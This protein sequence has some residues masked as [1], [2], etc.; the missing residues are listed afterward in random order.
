MASK[1]FGHLK[2]VNTNERRKEI[3]DRI[4]SAYQNVNHHKV[5]KVEQKNV[6]VIGRTRAGKTTIKKV[7]VDPTTVAEEMRLAAQTRAATFESFII[8]DDAMVVNI[9]DTPG[10]FEKGANN[11]N[12][13]DN[14][15][16]LKTIEQCVAREITKFHLICFCASFESGINAE[17]VKS[18]ILLTE[19]LGPAV[20]QNSCLIITRCES[21]NEEQ[22]NTL[23]K[24]IENDTLF[25]PITGYFQRGIF[26]SGSLDRDSWNN[27]TDNLY[28]QFETI[29]SYRNKLIDV[30]KENIEPFAVNESNI[31]QYRRSIEEEE[32]TTHEPAQPRD[33]LAP[34]RLM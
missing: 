7:L 10:L 34:C 9:I 14:K 21:K 26:F 22:R 12:L 6:L 13:M 1:M 17:D 15:T 31:T 18:I 8:D 16:I 2:N 20:S 30:L 32:R 27:A 11:M 25:K 4:K 24:E 3:E 23:R 29:V 19:F 33:R 5:R 28:Y